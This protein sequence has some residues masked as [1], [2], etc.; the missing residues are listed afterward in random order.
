[1]VLNT[2]KLETIKGEGRKFFFSRNKTGFM[3]NLAGAIRSQN[4]KPLIACRRAYRKV[5]IP[6]LI[7]S[8]ACNYHH[9]IFLIIRFPRLFHWQLAEHSLRKTKENN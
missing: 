7:R 4:R 3:P 6:D 5:R 2:E 8:G 9:V 1:M